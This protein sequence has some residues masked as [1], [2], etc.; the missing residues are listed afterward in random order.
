MYTL[1][2]ADK[3]FFVICVFALFQQQ[4]VNA[5]IVIGSPSLGFS[6]ACANESFNTF[7]TSFVFSP[8]DNLNSAN[9]FSIELSDAEGDFSEPIVVYTSGSGAI[10]TSPATLSFSLPVTTA[11]EN[12]RIRIKS[13]SPAASS[14]SSAAFAAYFKP[15]DTPFTINNLVS[16]AAFC[17][18]GSYLLSIDNP[19]TGSN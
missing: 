8:E 15:Q 12:Y 13:S 2:L 18:G 16:T 17:A 11:G 5:Q 6:Q 14:S 1:K 4:D 9:Q 19:G 3:W 7:N 10:T